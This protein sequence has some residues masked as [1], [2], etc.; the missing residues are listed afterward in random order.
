MFL[1][2]D[3][4]E[5]MLAAPAPYPPHG[6]AVTLVDERPV[7]AE[8]HSAAAW[9]ARPFDDDGRQAAGSSAFNANT[10]ISRSHYFRLLRSSTLSATTAAVSSAGR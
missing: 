8:P 4:L 3:D 1:L 2:E 7:F 9:A 6:A 10:L 5:A